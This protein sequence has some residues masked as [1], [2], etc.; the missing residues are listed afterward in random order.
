MW[1]CGRKNYITKLIFI[2]LFKDPGER[3]LDLPEL[4]TIKPSHTCW[5]A[6]ERF[7]KAVKGSYNIILNALNIYKQTHEPEAL[8]ISKVLRKLS[9]VF[10]I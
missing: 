3:V 8:E 4:K 2:G 7:V 1:S 9:T 5:L 10:A 6:H